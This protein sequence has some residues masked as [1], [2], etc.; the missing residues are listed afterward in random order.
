[1]FNSYVKLPEGKWDIYC[2]VDQPLVCLSDIFLIVKTETTLCLFHH[3]FQLKFVTIFLHPI[4][5]TPK[6][7]IIQWLNH[8]LVGVIPTPL[9]NMKVSWDDYS[10]YIEI[11]KSPYIN[12]V[13]PYINHIFMISHY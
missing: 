6:T 8:Y 4:F 2:F 11:Q 5:A 10:Q 13:F 3:I 7:S 1:M 9:K 12:H